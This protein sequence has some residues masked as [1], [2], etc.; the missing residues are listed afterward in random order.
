MNL[1]RFRFFII[2]SLVVLNVFMVFSI[3]KILDS[4]RVIDQ[5]TVLNASAAL[6]KKNIKIFPETIVRTTA[7]PFVYEATAFEV[8]NLLSSS[9]KNYFFSGEDIQLDEKAYVSEYEVPGGCSLE[10]GTQKISDGEKMQYSFMTF[11][12]TLEFSYS[13]YGYESYRVSSYESASVDTK[14]YLNK[15]RSFMSLFS[16]DIE[17][18]EIESGRVSDCVYVKVCQ[19][20]EGKRVK[21]CELTFVLSEKEILLAYGNWIFDSFEKKYRCDFAD[22][23]DAVYAINDS[24]ITE[25]VSQAFVYL[26]TRQEAASGYYIVPGWEMLCADSN[27]NLFEITY[28]ALTL[29]QYKNKK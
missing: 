15:I 13:V 11:K 28:D 20:L 18:E 16:N 14:V 4:G 2:I 1:N 21:N 29:S 10:F 26:Y 19:T 9:L 25:V 12:N 24:E 22:S 6:E 17:F 7:S 27:G 3:L 5:E 8:S 23:I